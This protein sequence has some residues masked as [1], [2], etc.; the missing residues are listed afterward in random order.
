MSS[1]PKRL[2]VLASAEVSVGKDDHGEESDGEGDRSKGCN[3]VGT[4]DIIGP[5]QGPI[6]VLGPNCPFVPGGG[7]PPIGG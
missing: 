2:A 6:Y 3:V 4:G 7:L 5:D 1:S